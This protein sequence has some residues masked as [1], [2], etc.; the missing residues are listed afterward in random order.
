[1]TR[2]RK[3][4]HFYY[5]LDNDMVYRHTI[6]ND[7]E[8]KIEVL[9]RVSRTWQPSYYYPEDFDEH[10]NDDMVFPFPD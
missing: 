5:N 10:R 1:M 2:T 6:T 7:S 4:Y 9:D 8:E 3:T